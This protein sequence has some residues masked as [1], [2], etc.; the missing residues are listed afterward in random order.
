MSDDDKVE[1]VPESAPPESSPAPEP[2][3]VAAPAPQ[4]P[5]SA[6]PQE[7]PTNM[8]TEAGPSDLEQSLPPATPE[9][10]Y[11][12][13]MKL[14]EDF[15]NKAID[16]KRYWNDKSALG[17]IGTIF[18]LLIGGIGSGLTKQPNA[19]LEMMNKEIDRDIE[20]QKQSKEGA[21]NF[22]KAQYAHNMQQ[23][24]TAHTLA[25]IQGLEAEN[26][27]KYQVGKAT[28]KRTLQSL[29]VPWDE[30]LEKSNAEVTAERD[31]KNA[32]I[33]SVGQHLED[34]SQGNPQA[35]AVLR[36]VV[37]PAI[38]AQ[39]KA[40]NDQNH[41]AVQLNTAKFHQKMAQQAGAGA[42]AMPGANLPKL[43]KDLA[44]MRILQGQNPKYVPPNGLTEN[45]AKSMQQESAD[46]LQN[47]KLGKIWNQ[48]FN[49]LLELP[50]M[51]ESAAGHTASFIGAA[52]QSKGPK[53][54]SA[55]GDE[56]KKRFERKRDSILASVRSTFPGKTGEERADMLDA[57]LPQWNDDADQVKKIFDR[58]ASHIGAMV[59]TP[60]L[61]MRSEYKMPEQ[62]YQLKV[63]KRIAKESPSKESKKAEAA[64]VGAWPFSLFK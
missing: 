28:A 42:M 43:Q 58:G 31:A 39:V 2:A 8:S 41:A 13:S 33:L 9:E 21:L 11:Q 55:L 26:V 22:L 10:R 23:A 51:G 38:A 57:Y 61:D 7:L 27:G 12:Q 50:N 62:K 37:H 54:T 29:G 47:N 64:S 48:G 4:G 44:E 60:T 3:P 32:Q 30:S 34:I 45:E 19:A 15:A 1:D 52:L 6:A 63:P 49:D 46:V 59:K 20:A 17:K 5:M 24:Q 18:G 35:Q 56:A 16:P 36:D 25:Q 40:N 14:A 53:G